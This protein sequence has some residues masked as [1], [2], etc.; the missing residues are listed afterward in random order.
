MK[1]CVAI[2]FVFMTVAS[3]FGQD[4]VWDK[5]MPFTTQNIT[6]QAGRAPATIVIS[7]KIMIAGIVEVPEWITLKFQNNGRLKIENES[8]SLYIR[9]KVSVGPQQIFDLTNRGVLTYDGTSISNITFFQN[10]VYHPEWWGLI[11]NEIPTRPDGTSKNSINYLLAKE[12]ML[13]IAASGGGELHFSEGVYYIRDFVID[14]D[15]ITVSGE[16]RKT[17]LRFDRSNFET[18]TRR[19]GLFTIQGPTTEKYYNKL[20]P[21]GAYQTGNFIFNSQQKTIQNIVVKNISI[22]WDEQSALEDP[23]M[24]GLTIVNAQNVIIDNVHVDLKGANRAFYI[25]TLFDGDITEN[26]TIQNS[27]CVASRT[28][29]LILHGFDSLDTIRRKIIL[30]SIIIKNNDFDVVGLP[31]IEQVKNG[32]LNVDYLDRYGSGV[33]FGG[34]EFT[35]TFDNMGDTIYRRIGSILI[36]N[37]TIRNADFGVLANFSNKDENKGFVHKVTLNS[38]SFIDFKYIGILSPFTNAVITNNTFKVIQLTPITDNVLDS[39]KKGYISSAIHIVKA[40]WEFFKSKHGPENITLEGNKVI[41]CFEQNTP[42][43]IQP[44]RDAT[45]TINNNIFDYDSSCS[46]PQNDII[47]TTSRRKFRTKNATVVLQNNIHDSSNQ[48]QEPASVLLDVRR[49]KHITLIE[50]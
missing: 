39:G 20:I 24:N 49:K 19:G 47:I 7:D 8:S 36:Q 25:G 45:I 50:Q 29:V 23:A 40:P 13:D 15:N 33:L 21:D 41:G 46:Q 37:N 16:G 44:N 30:D 9:G 5:V 34:S 17:I 10:K 35:T 26:I 14:F 28:G 43:I 12:M 22:E 18:S 6:N 42:F 2:F 31:S 38:N 1:R 4:L 48:S 27:S 32:Q 3:V 11:P